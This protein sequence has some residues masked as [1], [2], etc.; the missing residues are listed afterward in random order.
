MAEVQPEE[1]LQLNRWVWMARVLISSIDLD[2]YSIIG[3]KGAD[4][5]ELQ[6][7]TGASARGIG[8]LLDSL[9]PMGLL[10][11]DEKGVYHLTELSESSF[12]P[13]KPGYAGGRI[14]HMERLWESWGD[15]TAS[16]KDGLPYWKRHKVKGDFSHLVNLAEGLFPQNYSIGL[17][18]ADALKV[19]KSW[20]KIEILDV[21]AGSGA[22]S[23][24]FLTRDENA[25]ALA[26]DFQPVLDMAKGKARALGMENRF[27]VRAGNIREL[28]FGKGIFDLVILGHICHSEGEIHSKTLIEKSAAAL[29][30]GGKILIAEMLPDND[31][32]GPMFP[33]L[34]ALNM[35]VNTEEGDVFTFEQYSGWLEAAGMKNARLLEL[36]VPNHSPLIVAD[37][38]R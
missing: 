4:A 37:K 3:E 23:L 1:L 24:A 21:G 34:F 19:G 32:R 7:K 28:E 14:K 12:I 25:S 29:R 2:I 8:K 35:L 36:P 27:R 10:T 17:I 26:L 31:R 33:L 30:S 11:R 6:R 5:G 16:I 18:A 22:W 20:K 15:L 38:P 13:G 9:V